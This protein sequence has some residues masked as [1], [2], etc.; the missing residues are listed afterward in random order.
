MNIIKNKQHLIGQEGEILAQK[1][2]SKLGLKVYRP[3]EFFE[4]EHNI[5]VHS[6]PDYG[7]D[8]IAIDKDRED[9]YIIQ[10]KNSSKETRK[11]SKQEMNKFLD[12]A[13]HYKNLL[14][15]KYKNIY[16]VLMGKGDIN[17]EKEIEN[18]IYLNMNT[19]KNTNI[20]NVN[21]SLKDYVIYLPNNNDDYENADLPLKVD[22]TFN[23]KNDLDV[24]YKIRDLYKHQRD[25]IDFVFSNLRAGNRRFTLAMATGTGKTLTY[26]R[27]IIESSKL[28]GHE[29]FIILVPSVSLVAQTLKTIDYELKAHGIHNDFVFLCA[30]H[31]KTV[32]NAA[33]ENSKDIDLVDFA[34]KNKI[35]AIITTGM[36]TI[37]DFLIKHCGKK[38]IIISTYQSLDKVIMATSEVKRI[39]VNFMYDIAIMDEAHWTAG[40]LDQKNKGM[41]KKVH[42]DKNLPAYVRIYCTGTT[43]VYKTKSDKLGNVN[44]DG[45][46]FEENQI[47]SMDDPNIYGLTYRYSLRQAI[48]DGILA[49]YKIVTFYT[50]LYN[51][52]K[53]SELIE[54]L[55]GS[56]IK[57]EFLSMLVIIDALKNG[58]K[59]DLSS[60]S[61]HHYN[62]GDNIYDVKNADAG[63]IIEEIQNKTGILTVNSRKKARLLKKYFD[64]LKS[65]LG[66]ED[67]E[68]KYILGDEKHDVRKAKIDW[69]SKQ[70]GKI[71]I[72]ISVYVMR[73]GIDIPS[74]GFIGF[75]EKKSSVVDILQ[76]LGRVLRRHDSKKYAYVFVPLLV[77]ILS[78]DF[79]EQHAINEDSYGVLRDILDA[80]RSIDHFKHVRDRIIHARNVPNK[81]YSGKVD[82]TKEYNLIIKN[83]NDVINTVK[84]RLIDNMSYTSIKLNKR[85]VVY[86]SERINSL[87][88]K[89]K[90]DILMKANSNESF[91]AVIEELKK[92]LSKIKS[93]YNI[94]VF[95]EDVNNDDV[96]NLMCLNI[97][98]PEIFSYYI[99]LNKDPIYT[100]IN[101]VFE[102]YMSDYI[103]QYRE[104]VTKHMQYVKDKMYEI[105]NEID[106]LNILRSLFE[107]L[108]NVLFKD[109]MGILGAVYTPAEIVKFMVASVRHML[110][111][112][113]DKSILDRDVFF[114]D[115]FAGTGTMVSAIMYAIYNEA[116]E[117]GYD[118]AAIARIIE[119]YKVFGIEIHYIAYFVFKS[120]V[121]LTFKSLFDREPLKDIAMLGDT[122]KVQSSQIKSTGVD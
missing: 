106:K 66:F 41:Y 103:R 24:V 79:Q 112:Y 78:E 113:F 1:I 16:F 64:E 77:E 87:F 14:Q 56:D 82:Y 19:M 52:Y 32:K 59:V 81:I 83:M 49:D 42:E 18:F 57:Y 44:D 111:K 65:S 58:I 108:F 115:L 36:S 118:K 116:N 26:A 54:K 50:L 69:L 101:E 99:D 48:I 89:I 37:K 9:C 120:V 121:N 40:V 105:N 61:N 8:Y 97:I 71:K 90:G 43:V 76:H 95:S 51:K 55:V 34:D 75:L 3:L 35:E 73:E 31:D 110:T 6:R 33:K 68:I 96:I 94:Q 23:N 53:Y 45:N 22:K 88:K 100:P 63:Y 12:T 13:N 5:S 80:V 92:H 85:I 25:A 102:L 70:D 27:V 11:V 104:E 28:F 17:I 86:I 39:N 107:N 46:G 74:I 98:I 117:K 7:V 38:K 72:I 114:V 20:L 67:V 60:S 109:E 10:V 84:E 2:L 30:T 122:F 47:Y 29:T 119:N 4:N 21:I 15:G 91:K 93:E 62:N